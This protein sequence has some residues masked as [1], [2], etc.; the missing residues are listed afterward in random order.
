VIARKTVL[1]K[2]MLEEVWGGGGSERKGAE[3]RGRRCRGK[4]EERKWKWWES[5]TGESLLVN[6]P[7][8][9]L[10]RQLARIPV[11]LRQPAQ[12]LLDVGRPCPT[13]CSENDS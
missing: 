3:E 8:L 7:L 1:P 5:Q 2:I 13:R 9:Y 12:T 11:G 6:P 4:D 10:P